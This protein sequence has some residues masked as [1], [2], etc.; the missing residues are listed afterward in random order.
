[1]SHSTDPVGTQEFARP[2]RVP[3]KGKV[4]STQASLR[5]GL[6]DILFPRCAD[7]TI[8]FGQS[9]KDEP[10]SENPESLHVMA[11]DSDKGVGNQ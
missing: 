7:K 5:Y 9:E 11:Q 8:D 4:G 6:F 1:M 10:L 2:A 3:L